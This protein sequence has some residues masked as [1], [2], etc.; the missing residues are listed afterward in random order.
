MTTYNQHSAKQSNPQFLMTNQQLADSAVPEN[1]IFIRFVASCHQAGRD[2]MDVGATV[3]SADWVLLASLW[4]APTSHPADM[5]ARMSKRAG[6]WM[7]RPERVVR[8]EGCGGV[9]WCYSRGSVDWRVE[10]VVPAVSPIE[11]IGRIDLVR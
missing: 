6:K 2:P 10:A 11:D 8:V 9:S 5:V 1:R 4:E 3:V 7:W